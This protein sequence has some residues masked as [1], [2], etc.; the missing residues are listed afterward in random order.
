MSFFRSMQGGSVVFRAFFLGCIL[1]TGNVAGAQVDQGAVTGVV[2]DQDNA[3]IPGAQVTLTDTDTGLVLQRKANASGVYVFSPVK[4]GKYQVSAEAPGFQQTIQKNL[5]LNLQGR[6]NVDLTLQPGAVSET[7]TVTTAPPMLQTQSSAVGQVFSTQSINDTPLNGRNWVY[8]AQLSAGVVA[9][10]GS[11]GGQTGDFSANGQRPD[12]NDFLLD[13]VDNNVN[14]ADYQN[15]ASFNVRPPPDAL[16]EFQVQTSNYSAEFGHSVGA[17]LNASIKSGTNQVHGDLW[18]YF[19]NTALADKD[20]DALVNPPYH[21]NQFG[22]TLGVPILRDKLFYFG[23]AEANRITFSKTNTINVPTPLMRQG[24]F[25]EL[26]TPALTGASNPIQLYTPN[27]GGATKLSCNGQSNVLCPSQIDP[28]AQNILNL[29]P[30]PN[31]NGGD[32]YNNYIENLA[33]SVNTWQWDQRVDYNISSKDQFYTRYSYQ[34]VQQKNTAPLGPILD[35]TGDYSGVNQDFLSESGMGSETHIFNPNLVNEFRF[36]YNWGSF[37]NLQENANTNES[38]T[39]GLGGIPFGAGFPENGGLPSVTVSGIQAFGT[40]GFDPS[41][42]KQNLYQILD[43]VTKIVGNHSLKFG[44]AFQSIRS[45]SLSP[46]TSRGSYTFNGKYTS[47]PSVS[48]TTG[49]GVADFLVDQ[50]NS[51]SVGNETT[52]NFSRWYRSGYAQD[53]W[54]LTHRFTLNLG[55]RY[56]YY[57]SPKE[58]ANRQANLV[59]TSAGVGTGTGIFQLP[60]EDQ[61]ITLAPAYTSLL[62]TEGVSLQYINNPSLVTVQET[63]FAPRVGFAFTVDPQTVLR[64]GFGIFYGGLEPYGGDNIGQN[65]PF[66]TTATFPAGNCNPNNCPSDGL[67]LE[68]GFTAPLA[69]GLDSFISSPTFS[70]TDTN[71]KTPNTTGYNLTAERAFGANFVAT[72]GYVGNISRRLPTAINLNSARALQ[73]SSIAAISAEPFPKF[74]AVTDVAYEGQSMYNSLQS[75]LQKRFSSGLQFL[76]TYTWAHTMDDSAD[77]LNGGITYRNANLIPLIDEY[78]NSGQDVRNRFTFNGNYQLPFGV[79]RTYLNHHGVLDEIAGGWS[80]SLTFVAQSGQPFTVTPNNTGP[81][82]ASNRNA[83]IQR[84]PSSL[85]G[86]VDATNTGTVCATSTH[87]RTHWY[88]PCA[89]ANPLDG[90]TKTISTSTKITGVANVI[91]YLGGR[92]N[93]I[94]GPGYNRVNMSLFKNFTTFREQFLQ[95]RADVFNLANHPSF[96]NPS[97]SG[98]NTSGGQITSAKSL[99]ANSP[100]ARFFQVSAKYVF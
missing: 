3:A 26:L 50:V 76:A 73:A 63:N 21:E 77:P 89:F 2:R 38:A 6:L 95:F 29:Y 47:A 64:G 58:M 67:T 90:T 94:Y 4:I 79:G 53:D 45:S 33:Y 56:D 99:Q 1:F 59:V 78:T 87:N 48:I 93:L 39:L 25:S 14:I 35:G 72:L 84:D 51:G 10:T 97:S 96:A 30:L 55:L 75:K 24:N 46:P 60:S 68:T 69:V 74:G 41:I 8:M 22:A 42:K 62:A 57:Q 43:N 34:H 54:K 88:N 85:G 23:D 52:E 70:I 80:A 81:S 66:F 17:V 44:V 100:D 7:V 31:A 20:W 32:T 13:G 49:Y 71:I 37:S 40:H 65:H 83:I 92:S 18:E 5:Q 91:P 19:R 15:G 36:S 11:R 98:I 28:V 86:P 61:N 27:S 12:Q 82:G 16:A 9:T